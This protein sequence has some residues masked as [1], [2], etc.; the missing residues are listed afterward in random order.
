MYLQG[1]G[2][3]VGA[4][5]WKLKCQTNRYG[6]IRPPLGETV[7]YLMLWSDRHKAFFV[8]IIVNYGVFRISGSS[9][10]TP[11]RVLCI[12]FPHLHLFGWVQ[13]Q[14]KT[15]LF[16]YHLSTRFCLLLHTFAFLFWVL[17]FCLIWPFL[18]FHLSVFIA[19]F[20]KQT[21]AREKSY[22]NGTLV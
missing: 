11:W 1:K 2:Y 13:C 22:V 9:K 14:L 4:K 18:L 10:I 21:F 6:L 12:I 16:E 19:L 15:L 5:G 7:V 20:P 8:F 3:M 17:F